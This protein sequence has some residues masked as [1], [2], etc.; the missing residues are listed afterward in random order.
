MG[1]KLVREIQTPEEMPRELQLDLLVD[2]ELPEQQR[3]ALLKAMDERP[4]EWRE[5]ALRFLQRQVEKETVRELTAG[6][7]LVPVDMMPRKMVAGWVGSSRMVALAAGMLIAVTS[8]LITLF[9]LQTGNNGGAIKGPGVV[10]TGASEFMA[11]IPADAMAADHNIDMSVPLVKVRDGQAT[12]FP[13][14]NGEG[15]A[16]ASQSW[17]IQPDGKGKAVLIPVN[18][19]KAKVY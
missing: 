19:L 13:A 12:L 1:V 6:G 9:A 5:L 8:A 3:S 11:S 10:E 17:V 2:A 15:M 14:G 7:S 18:T 16:R 4:E